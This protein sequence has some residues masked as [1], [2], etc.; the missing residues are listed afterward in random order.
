MQP[1]RVVSKK[2]GLLIRD[3]YVDEG[4]V[5]LSQN[6]KAFIRRAPITKVV[7]GSVG[8]GAGIL[9]K[10]LANFAL[11]MGLEMSAPM[12]IPIAFT[13]GGVAFIVWGILSPLE[14]KPK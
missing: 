4:D 10:G 12:A 1:L 6:V 9:F 8:V 14:E 2:D 11:A 13:V 3:I 7:L 5:I